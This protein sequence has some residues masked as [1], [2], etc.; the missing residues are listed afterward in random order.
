MGFDVPV[1][2]IV[3]K[4]LDLTERSFAPIRELKP[5]KFYII[6]DGPKD[7]KD[8]QQVKAVRTYIEEHIDW[9]CEVHKNYAEKNMGLRYRMPSGRASAPYQAAAAECLLEKT[10]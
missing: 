6:S 8:A 7:R 9:P 1:V 2:M 5:E 3:Y 10:V 4:R